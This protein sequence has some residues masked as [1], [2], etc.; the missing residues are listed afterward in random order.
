MALVF[1]R[2][3]VGLSALSYSDLSPFS[4]RINLIMHVSTPSKTFFSYSLMVVSTAASLT[5]SDYD[6]VNSWTAITGSALRSML[7]LMT[8]VAAA[9]VAVMVTRSA[10]FLS[11]VSS[12]SSSISIL[13]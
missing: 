2:P 8:G 6:V 9:V 4:A 1:M 5:S 3:I 10:T 13:V 11:S 12:G 7:S